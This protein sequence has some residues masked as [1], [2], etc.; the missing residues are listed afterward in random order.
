M[1]KITFFLFLSI[2]A[3]STSIA[4]V[5][6]NASFDN[7]TSNTFPAYDEPNNWKT[8][9]PTSGLL[10]V[11]TCY[12][13]TG[14]DV[15]HGAAALK[16]VTKSV[17]GQIANGIATTGTINTTSQSIGGGLPYT[18]RP[19]SIGGYYKY[20]PV[21]GDNGFVELQ[22]LGA[23]GDTDTVGY[24]RFKTPTTA[25]NSY[26]YFSKE[27]TYKKTTPVVKALWII[28]SS[29]DAVTHY[30]NSTLFVDNIKVVTNASNVQEQQKPQVLVGPNP[31]NGHLVIKNTITQNIT[32]ELYDVT[33][34]KIFSKQI[35]ENISSIDVSNFPMGLYIYTIVDENSNVIKTDK[36]IFQK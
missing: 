20:T 9:N 33:G 34:R 26:T 15:Q 13:A 21:S 8:L 31:S 25:V 17:A 36:L 5:L 19:D 29:K 2:F 22:L 10:G 35:N 27:I 11:I 16:L 1:K 18:G 12:K 4:Q 32:L 6:P 14:A 3:L 7:W 23:G 24:V 28:S 30:V